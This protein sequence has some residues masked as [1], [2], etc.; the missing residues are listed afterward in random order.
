MCTGLINYKQLDTSAREEL[1][2]KMRLEA[3]YRPILT[4]LFNL[5]LRDFTAV[6]AATGQALDA[7][8]YRPDFDASLRGQ[9]QRVQRFFTGRIVDSV[10]G[11]IIRLKQNQEEDDALE[12][13]ILAALVAWRIDSAARSSLVISNTNQHQMQQAITRARQQIAD[14]GLPSD[15]RTLARVS[16]SNLS[17]SFKGRIERII[18][19]ETQAAAEATRA[20][21]ASAISGKVPFPL[22]RIEGVTPAVQPRRVTKTWRD[23]DDNK[24]RDSHTIADGTTIDENAIFTVGP[25]RSRLRFPGDMLLGAVTAEVINC[26]CF[27][28]YRLIRG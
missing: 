25:S 10:E 12:A 24:V 11:K 20:I 18:V 5:V 1:D 27:A 2:E 14:Q 8:N 19:T 23:I 4:R 13:L 15:N 28:D 17:R 3:I 7:R 16:R 22:E 9:Y 26:R 21:E 6:V